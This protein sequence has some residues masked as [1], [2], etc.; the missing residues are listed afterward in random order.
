MTTEQVMTTQEIADRLV[1]LCREGKYNQV[2]QE[3]FSPDCWSIE[4]E[5]VPSGT[6]K[7]M[8]A[9]QE[10]GKL[11]NE[12]V[13]T[14]HSGSL[15]DPLVAADHFSIAWF[16]KIT[17]KGA[18]GPIDMDEIAVYKVANGK[19]VSEQFFYTPQG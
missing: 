12:M 11:W 10:K 7:G 13:E 6:A 16:S 5:G 1:E 17:M 4:P 2:Y 3:L 9:M 15:S 8:A 18:P 19:V 14:F